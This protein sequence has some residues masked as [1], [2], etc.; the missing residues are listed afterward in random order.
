MFVCESLRRV[1]YVRGEYVDK[2]T[3]EQRSK[4]MS[5]IHSEN[6]SI[7]I[8]LRKA[9]WNK[10]YRYR[11][12]YN[13]LPGKPDIALTKHKIAIFCDGEFFHGKDWEHLK[14]QLE[15]SNNGQFWIEK[16]SKNREI[17]ERIEKELLFRGWK[18]LRF[19]GRDIKRYTNECVK[20]IEETILDQM[21]EQESIEWVD[22]RLKQEQLNC[23]DENRLE[24]Q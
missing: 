4:N 14:L 16:I 7:E 18:V 22:L 1:L 10:G 20:V 6:T 3:K 24:I 17:D 23:W 11:K 19:W 12:N 8:I 9:L 13:Q 2:L 15:N 21:I 5:K